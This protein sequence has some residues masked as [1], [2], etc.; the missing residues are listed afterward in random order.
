MTPA[1]AWTSP[2]ELPDLRRAGVVAID[3]ETRDE[4]LAAGRGSSWFRRGGFV[5]G[6]SVA[7]REE[8]TLRSL[9]A[10]IQHPDTDNFPRENVARWVRDLAASDVRLL[11]QNGMYDWG[12]LRA[13]LQVPTPPSERMEEL[14][15]A[16]TIVD[17]N[18]HEYGLD[19]LCRWL[20]LPGK[21]EA[22]LDEALAAYGFPTNP[23]N[24]KENLWRLPARYVGP[25]AEADPR[26]T[27]E[28]WERLMP[29]VEAEGTTEAYRL[30]VDLLPL[31]MERRRRGVRVD[32]DAAERARDELTA[33]RDEAFTELGDRLGERV[34][35]EEIG[36]T[37]WL[38]A[39]FAHHA[40]EIRVP[41][42]APS[43][44]FPDGQASFTAGSTGW[45]HKERHWLPRLIVRA[46]KLNNAATKFLQ[47][48]ILD[49]ATAGRIHA[50]VHPHR[51]DDGGTRSLRLSYSDPPLQQMTARDEELA[52]LIRGVFLP[53]EGEVWAKPDVSQQEY[54]FIVDYACQAGPGGTPLPKAQEA[55]QMY[56]D[57]PNTDFHD[58]CTHM[59]NP[60]VNFEGMSK[61]E[62]KRLRKPMK[63]TNF[64]KSFGAGVPKFAAM[65]GASIEDA[66]RLYDQYDERLPF[67]H[68]LFEK[69]EKLAQKRG[70]IV[71]YDG[72]RRHWA[73]WEPKYLSKEQRSE[74][75]RRGNRMN[76]C[77]RDEAVARTQ[78]ENHVWHGRGL[79][80]SDVRKAMNGLIQGSAAR[81][82]K[83]WMRAVWREGI[84][85][86]L[87]LHDELDC[88]VKSREE[89][90]LI[91]RLG[92][93][94]VRLRIPINVDVEYGRSW[95]D[96]KHEWDEVPGA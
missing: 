19:A 60:G 90:E 39:R 92:Q 4:G 66:Q 80:R 33:K 68:L 85:P 8:G 24:K 40:K 59:F 72:A 64:A 75:F 95:G 13:D 9:Y 32:I 22:L 42:T 86:L 48:Y 36:R 56:R 44:G 55:A 76:S 29:T 79:R 84:V 23:R 27:L 5:T 77:S 20:G 35:M 89:G 81:H 51:S 6:V 93:D 17:E 53:E 3:T 58:L 15:A 34:G 21:D 38:E 18:R 1:S 25:Y 83:L 91:R 96:A 46:D 52:P 2:A 82:T 11:T 45:M 67:V 12:W 87:Q 14:G 50:E 28:A 94:A 65:I 73:E 62:F 61:D 31:I 26:Q 41:R 78:D 74:G 10:P 7:W 57:D 47:G 49:Y 69:C 37:K 16:A 54:R 88:S 43:R 70:Y 30:E 63:D 71:L